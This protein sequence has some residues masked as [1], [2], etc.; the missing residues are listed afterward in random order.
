MGI[1]NKLVEAWTSGD[2]E[3]IGACYSS[4]AQVQHPMAPAPLSGREAVK[5]FEAG[6]FSAFSELKWVATGVVE[7][8]ESCAVE[9]RVTA[10]NSAPLQTPKGTLP[11]TNR[12]V[13]VRG[14]SLLTLDSQGRIRS[15]HRYFDTAAMFVQLGLAG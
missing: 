4:A 15:E 11:P 7:N 5:Q 13:D 3:K 2:I 14:M 8:G 12:S 9:F 10:K 1:A 6:M